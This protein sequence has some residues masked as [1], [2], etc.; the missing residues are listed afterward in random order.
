MRIQTAG[1]FLM[2]FFAAVICGAAELDTPKDQPVEITSTGETR[3]ENGIAFARDNVA[4]HFGDSDIYAD[5]AQYDSKTHLVSAAGNVRIYRG[6]KLYTADH[7]SYNTET[8]EILADDLRTSSDPYL[9]A[10]NS[11]ETF[12]DGH[13]QVQNGIFTT[14]DQADPDFHF[15]ARKVRIYE[16][17]RV[18]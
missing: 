14:D 2:L 6:G 3:Y 15:R 10:G 11:L 4:I 16:N 8:K 9:V 17:D 18:I 1:T 7:G 5:S 12:A 13:Y